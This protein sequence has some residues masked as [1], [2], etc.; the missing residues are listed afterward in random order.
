M[1]DE[2]KCNHVCS[3]DCRRDGCIEHGCTCGGEWHEDE[4]CEYCGGTGEVPTDEDDGEGHIQ[5]GVGTRMCIC[6]AE[7]QADRDAE[8]EQ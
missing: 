3:S 8:P 7:A 2:R 5:R 1:T 6:R 4:E